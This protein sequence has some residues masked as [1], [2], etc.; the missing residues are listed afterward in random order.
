ME[1]NRLSLRMIC[2]FLLLAG[3]LSSNTLAAP[4]DGNGSLKLQIIACAPGT[5]NDPSL[6][7]GKY[8]AGDATVTI[9][10]QDSDFSFEGYTDRLGQLIVQDL[11][12]GQN[13]YEILWADFRGDS[14]ISKGSVYIKK[15][16]LSAEL[17]DLKRDYVQAGVVE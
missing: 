7:E 3:F 4:L 15:G 1:R 16:E 9:Y 13:K 11:P 5:F 8:P 14:W 6:A 12:V 2:L 10:R 17:V